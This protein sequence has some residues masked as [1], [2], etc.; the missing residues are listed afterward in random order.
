MNKPTLHALRSQR[1]ATI[2]VLSSAASL[3]T[4]AFVTPA[5]AAPSRERDG[6]GENDDDDENDPDDDRDPDHSD[7]ENDDNDDDD[8]DIDGAE[9]SHL[10]VHVDSEALGGAWSS[11]DGNDVDGGGDTVTFGAG[12]A[13][14][15]LLDDGAIFSRPLFGFGLGWVFAEDRAVLGAKIGLTVDGYGIDGSRPTVAA[16]GRFVPYFH[17]MF[18]PKR[19]VRPWLEARVGLGG[20][21]SSTDVPDIGRRRDSVIYPIVGAGG[22]VH[23]F[24]RDWFSVDLGF[25]LD[26]AAPYAR[27]TFRADDQTDTDWE[28]AADVVNFGVLLGMSTWF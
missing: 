10:R 6:T 8:R 25:N 3:A 12:L 16:G 7:D 2:L 1:A 13:R 27:T 19:M 22:G 20:S 17:W 15:S 5:S 21:A 11:R 26:Y 9:D 24:P 14:P 23:I 18:L 4:A 28:K